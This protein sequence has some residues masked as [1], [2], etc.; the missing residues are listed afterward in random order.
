MEQVE[1]LEGGRNKARLRARTRERGRE[2]AS[3]REY[4]GAIDEDCLESACA[5]MARG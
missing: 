4:G 2:L 1:G 5:E 3:T